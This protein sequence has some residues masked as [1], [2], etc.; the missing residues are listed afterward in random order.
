[1][2][3]VVHPCAT[4]PSPAQAQ[5]QNAIVR[6][7]RPFNPREPGFKL[8][9]TKSASSLG[10]GLPQGKPC[11]IK[12]SGFRPVAGRPAGLPERKLS[13]SRWKN[14][15]ARQPG[16]RPTDGRELTG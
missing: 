16:L 3:M 10:I 14:F 8:T 2:S 12:A 4:T 7:L 5:L 1:M 13:S 11:D 15:C 6:R 9:A